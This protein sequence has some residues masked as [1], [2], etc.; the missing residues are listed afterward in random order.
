MDERSGTAVTVSP[1]VNPDIRGA[2]EQA[3]AHQRAGRLDEA[4]R[5]SFAARPGD[6]TLLAQFFNNALGNGHDM[7]RRTERTK[8]LLNQAFPYVFL[9]V[10]YATGAPIA[11]GRELDNGTITCRAFLASGQNNMAAL[12]SWLR[13][14][15]AG[16]TGAI[17]R[18]SPDAY[19]GRLGFY[20]QQHPD[21][22][23]IEASEK[24]LTE[25]DHGL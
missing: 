14:Y 23:L 8:K 12:I 20:C 6:S 1:A 19:G 24:I 22:N 3:L 15:H 13:G 16:K 9:A 18:Q 10:V 21:D 7:V 2:L 5:T 4:S 17:R 25:L 11:D